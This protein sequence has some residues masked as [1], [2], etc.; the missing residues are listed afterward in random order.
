MGDKENYIQLVE[1]AR[2]GDEESMS[3]LAERVRGPLCMYVHRLTLDND[4]TQDI[5]Q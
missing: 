3:R 2:S 4:L 1:Q 5:L